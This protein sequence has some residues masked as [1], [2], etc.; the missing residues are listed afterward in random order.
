MGNRTQRSRIGGRG[1]ALQQCKQEEERPESPG[2]KRGEPLC[3]R[4]Q[5]GENRTLK[6][7]VV[8]EDEKHEVL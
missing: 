6:G 2:L 7:A 8:K 5:E 3:L 1:A 4:G